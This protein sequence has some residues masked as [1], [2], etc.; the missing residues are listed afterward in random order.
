[1]CVVENPTITGLPS[2]TLAA[3]NSPMLPGV[4]GRPMNSAIARSASFFFS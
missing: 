4:L 2:K 3:T 1:V